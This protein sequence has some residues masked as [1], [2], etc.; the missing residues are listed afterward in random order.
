[1]LISMV[2]LIVLFEGSLVLA[3]FLGRPPAEPVEVPSP[4]EPTPEPPG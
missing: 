1:M 3:R 2:P 4:R